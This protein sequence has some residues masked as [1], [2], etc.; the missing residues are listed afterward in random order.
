MIA[1]YISHF[2]NFCGLIRSPS[3][4]KLGMMILHS[5]RII[6]P[7]GALMKGMKEEVRKWEKNRRNAA[8]LTKFVTLEL[9]CPPSPFPDLDQIWHAKVG[10]AGILPITIM[11]LIDAF[12]SQ[13]KYASINP[14][15]NQTCFNYWNCPTS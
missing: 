12:L 6:S 8:I 3:P 5:R 13:S 2:L 10:Y 7:Y 15:H 9:L 14:T 4:T 11:D 1:S